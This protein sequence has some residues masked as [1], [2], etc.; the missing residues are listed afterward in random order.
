MEKKSKSIQKKL[1]FTI[2]AVL[3]SLLPITSA[4]AADQIMAVGIDRKFSYNL[5][6]SKY[7]GHASGHDEVQFYN[8]SK[9]GNPRLIG[10]VP[11][12]NSVVGP[13]TNIAITPDQTIALIASAITTT[14]AETGSGWKMKAA[15]VVTVVDLTSNP[16]SVVGKVEVGKKASGVSISADGKMALVA[17]RGSKSISVLSINGH[18][19][20]LTD[21][22]DMGEEVTSVAITP[23][24]RRAFVAKFT[25][26]RVAELSI[27]E[28]GKVS[29]TGRDIPVG[30]YPWVVTID[31]D[32]T[33]A[34]VTNIGKAGASDGS[35]KTV[36]VIDLTAKPY[37]RTIEHVT[38]GDAPEGLVFSPNGKFAA[39]T[40]LGG[41]YAVPKDAWYRRDVGQ[42]SVL[43][44]SDKGVSNADTVKV[45]S[46][47]EGIAFS[48][49][50]SH[51][52][53]GNFGSSS[54]S[55]VKLKSDGSVDSV[56]E[57][58]LPGPPGSLRVAGQ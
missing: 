14:P 2:G 45:G 53:I 30:P 23:D 1:I 27:D 24:G 8:L 4:L 6:T 3:G 32:G 15:N 9:P 5:Q 40:I 43:T 48:S 33:R 39:A 25:S 21:T 36:S 37:A 41:S 31:R 17:N 11:V 7:T 35:A 52:Y 10:S 19:V 26:H 47:P 29:Y 56:K 42:L 20:K 54:L 51:L 50:S 49:D 18:K 44:R 22:L 12:E 28:S 34:M 13:P 46:F 16:I 57:I 58:K 55:V 38:V